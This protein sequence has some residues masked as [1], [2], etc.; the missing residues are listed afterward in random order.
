[1]KAGVLW[2]WERERSC[3]SVNGLMKGT[4]Y[5]K[6]NLSVK[7]IDLLISIQDT[8]LWMFSNK[9]KMLIL[10]FDTI[11][12]NMYWQ[13]YVC[14]CFA[15]LI[16]LPYRFCWVLFLLFPLESRSATVYSLILTGWSDVNYN[17]VVKIWIATSSSSPPPVPPI[18]SVLNMLWQCAVDPVDIVTWLIWIF[19]LGS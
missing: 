7:T 8:G 5:I 17:Y 13:N 4:T 16:T 15:I 12:V 6:V 3:V 18:P 2:D 19:W 9:N 1:M 11:S 14:T 10:K